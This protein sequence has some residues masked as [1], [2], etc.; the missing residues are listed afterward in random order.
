[1]SSKTKAPPRPTHL[2]VWD[3]FDEVLSGFYE[4]GKND[5]DKTVN[6]AL[7]RQM[8]NWSK[9]L[10][11]LVAKNQTA[12]LPGMEPKP[13]EIIAAPRPRPQVYIV[14]NDGVVQNM[15]L[16]I[17]D[18]VVTDF[19]LTIEDE[20]D[21]PK[22]ATVREATPE[23]TTE[24]AAEEPVG[25]HGGEADS[26]R[27]PGELIVAIAKANRKAATEANIKKLE[28]KLGRKNKKVETNEVRNWDGVKVQADCVYFDYEDHLDAQSA[29]DEI[30][31]TNF[32][33][34]ISALVDVVPIEK[35]D[36]QIELQIVVTSLGE[37]AVSEAK[38]DLEAALDVSIADAT[39]DNQGATFFL[40]YPTLVA[41]N[42]AAEVVR[43]VGFDFVEEVIVTDALLGRL[44]D[45][46]IATLRASP[47][48][49]LALP[50]NS[51]T[52]ETNLCTHCGQI[53]HGAKYGIAPGVQ[54]VPM[55][56]SC[57]FCGYSE[58]DH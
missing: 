24:A 36:T 19:G 27:G 22:D 18:Q 47:Q 44:S 57:E 48:V 31:F 41:A 32:A 16:T 52:G 33:F 49:V 9:K 26:E 8:T 5:N 37:Q 21:G 3:L 28:E 54:G 14:M 20:A 43:G 25:S 45:D 42:V 40:D 29:A 11:K 50:S 23:A 12:P 10:D 6:S 1:M 34:V 46:E 38:A 2:L 58:S 35:P 53:G 56:D 13:E 7:K 39:V 55:D 17:D 4:K 15:T 51:A 30:D